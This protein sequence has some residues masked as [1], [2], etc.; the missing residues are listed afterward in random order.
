MIGWWVT[1]RYATLREAEIFQGLDAETL[2]RLADAHRIHH[3]YNA[4]PYGMLL[5]IVPSELRERAERTDRN[6]LAA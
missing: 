6:P 1:L 2:D 5:P 3:L 4:A